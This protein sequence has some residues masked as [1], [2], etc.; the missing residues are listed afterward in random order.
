MVLLKGRHIELAR[1]SIAVAS[2]FGLAAALSVVLLGDESGYSATHTQRMKLAAMEGMWETHEAPADFTLVGLP[3]QEARENHYAIHIPYA[4]GLIATRSLTTEIPGINDLV[5]ESQDRIR[6]G[7]VAYDAL[8]TIREEREDT[9]QP[10]LD[11]FEAHGA[12]LGYAFLLLKYTDDPRNATD[13]QIVQAA[14]DTVPTVWPLF[15]A[16]RIMVALGLRVH[17]GDAV[18]LHPQQ[19]RQPRLS[20]LGACGG[21]YSPSRRRGSRPKWAGSWPSSD[22]NPGR[23]TASCP[24]PCRSATCR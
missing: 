20:A 3:D 11:R 9:P 12:D 10:V 19:F 13:A 17:R 23:W 22:A 5:L 1:R 18:L 8:M 7:I 4:M 14:D 2:S 16:F 15:W 21:R 6:N 24:R